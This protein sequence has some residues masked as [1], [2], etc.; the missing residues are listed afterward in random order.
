MSYTYKITTV[1]FSAPMTSCPP[2]Y[3]SALFPAFDGSQKC[4][5]IETEEGPAC[6]V[7][8]ATEQTPADLGPLVRVERVT[9]LSILP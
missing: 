7:T 5:L 6:I 9:D 8:F 2:P 4:K 1:I 3:L